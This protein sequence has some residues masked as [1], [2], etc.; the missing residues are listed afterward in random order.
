MP[1]AEAAGGIF[2]RRASLFQR[3]DSA[4]VQAAR[5]KHRFIDEKTCVF[6]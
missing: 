1:P 5:Y 4:A 6:R 3:A 2:I